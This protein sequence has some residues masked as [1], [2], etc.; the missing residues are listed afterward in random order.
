MRKINLFTAAIFSIAFLQLHAQN[1][2]QKKFGNGS[3][4]LADSSVITGF[5]RENIR[6]NSSLSVITEAGGKKKTYN[7]NELLAAEIDSARFLCIKGD[8]FK[9][10]CEGELLFLQKESDASRKPVYNG[11]EALFINGTEGKINDYFFYDSKLQQL[12]LVTKKNMLAVVDGSFTNCTAA[13]NKARETGDDLSRLGL[14][15]EI[16]NNRNSK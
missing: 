5:I 14:A 9:V 15:V 12:K 10:M 11:S 7:G 3:I 8:F 4:M 16:Y 1:E 13:I 6:G 2:I